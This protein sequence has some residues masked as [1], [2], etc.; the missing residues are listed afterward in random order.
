MALPA[1]PSRFGIV[2]TLT[3]SLLYTASRSLYRAKG[4]GYKACVRLKRKNWQQKS[5][6]STVR[7]QSVSKPDERKPPNSRTGKTK[8]TKKNSQKKRVATPQMTSPSYKE[9]LANSQFKSNQLQPVKSYVQN[10][11]CKEPAASLDP[12]F[13]LP[14]GS[15]I[16]FFAFAIAYNVLNKTQ[17]DLN[18]RLLKFH[19]TT[20]TSIARQQNWRRVPRSITEEH[21]LSP[22]RISRTVPTSSTRAV[23]TKPN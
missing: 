19:S 23:D 22:S 8:K 21:K 15:L 20:R 13:L 7:R 4:N 14:L 1:L 11:S 2:T 16:S 18:S 3:G 10:Q 17:S 12:Q 9:Q 6:R 5:C